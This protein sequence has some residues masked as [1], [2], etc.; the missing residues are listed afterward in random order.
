MRREKT[1]KE[2]V[3]FKNPETRIDT[4]QF[5]KKYFSLYVN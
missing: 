3:H 1:K 5:N 2:S 4:Y